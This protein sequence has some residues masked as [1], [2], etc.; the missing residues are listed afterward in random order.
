MCALLYDAQFVNDER[1]A[2]DWWK[3]I[4]DFAAS[5]KAEN[6]KA[7]GKD[8]CGLRIAD[9]GFQELLNPPNARVAAR[10]TQSLPIEFQSH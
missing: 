4:A 10:L 3:G 9:F 7:K 2:R 5:G 6:Q 8:D 1:G